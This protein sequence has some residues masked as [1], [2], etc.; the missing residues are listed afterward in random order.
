MKLRPIWTLPTSGDGAVALTF[1]DGPNPPY[2]LELIEVLAHH[3]VPATFFVT[4][5]NA[6]THPD[7]VRRMVDAGMRVGV[8]S[9]DHA[10][11]VR[12]P[13]SFVEDQI[14]RTLSTLRDLG[15]APELFRAPFQE[16]DEN[17]LDVA[18][19]AGLV[20]IV[21][22]V[23]AADWTSPAADVIA[24]RVRALLHPGAIVVLHDGGG[25][26]SQTVAAVPLIID[27]IAAAGLQ[28]VDLI[29][30]LTL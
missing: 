30:Q 3:A 21:G 1:D 27:D 12:R 25:E 16:W 23:D 22:S 10:R 11:L 26:R 19:E 4:G 17:V 29:D 2:T 6:R 28:I 15:A 24:A 5:E 8:H 14:F 9:W 18:F 7:V 13:R 20:T